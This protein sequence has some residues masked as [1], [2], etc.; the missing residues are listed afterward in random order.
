MRHLPTASAEIFKNV[1]A[2]PGIPLRPT[3]PPCPYQQAIPLG[4]ILGCDPLALGRIW[5]GLCA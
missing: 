1:H 3:L 2:R 4:G 5:R